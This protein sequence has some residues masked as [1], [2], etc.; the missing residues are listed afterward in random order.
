MRLNDFV[1][2]DGAVLDRFREACRDVKEE[3]LAE[4]VDRL[5]AKIGP[6]SHPESDI[7]ICFTL[8]I[9]VGYNYSSSWELKKFH[10]EK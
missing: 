6:S 4:V 9:V 10:S 7:R 2:G 3:E 1:P 5:Q 8:F